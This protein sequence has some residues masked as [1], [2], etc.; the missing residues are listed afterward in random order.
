M[1]HNHIKDGIHRSVEQ[2][3]IVNNFAA[4]PVLYNFLVEVE[5]VS[6]T[7][8]NSAFSIFNKYL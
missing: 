2:L 5:D 1:N 3:D 6:K 7:V 8:S 4:V